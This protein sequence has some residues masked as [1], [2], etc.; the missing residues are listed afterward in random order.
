M[1][2]SGVRAINADI[3]LTNTLVTNC[4]SALINVQG[5]GNYTF[6]HC[7]FTNYSY[8]FG[9]ESAAVIISNINRALP[10][11]AQLTTPLTW[12]IQNSIIWGGGNFADEIVLDRNPAA[13]FTI[14]AENNI[15]KS[16]LTDIFNASNLLNVPPKPLFVDPTILNFRPDTLS[17]MI[18]AG[19]QL[20][21]TQDI[22]GKKRD[23]KPDIGA[24]E[25]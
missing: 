16:Q 5:G 15:V 18:N 22:T 23:A 19:T 9:R 11:N 25:R 4:V 20:G 3:S 2:Q 6:R 7:T 24:Y 13:S 14:Q 8:D 21:V 10:Q 17:P 12:I 1:L